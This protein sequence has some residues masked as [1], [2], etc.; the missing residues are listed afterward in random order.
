MTNASIMYGIIKPSIT[1]KEFVVL[2]PGS[3]C[4]PGCMATK[5]S[6]RKYRASSVFSSFEVQRESDRVGNLLRDRQRSV[7]VI[8]RLAWQYT[9]PT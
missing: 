9:R 7:K 8:I 6:S 5:I 4:L 2:V 3:Y 1:N